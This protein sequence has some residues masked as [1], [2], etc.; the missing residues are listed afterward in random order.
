M[1][2]PGK[3]KSLRHVVFREEN[4]NPGRSPAHLNSYYSSYLLLR[5]D[6]INV[7]KNFFSG[8]EII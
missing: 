3:N 4:D 6:I 5:Y 1:E 7:K 8:N 2:F